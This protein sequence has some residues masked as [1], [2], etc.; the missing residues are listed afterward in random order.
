MMR[1]SFWRRLEAVERLRESR[2][3]ALGELDDFADQT[4]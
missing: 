1:E 3:C 2:L 4:L